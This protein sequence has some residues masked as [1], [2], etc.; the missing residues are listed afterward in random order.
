[1]RPSFSSSSI[2]SP[3]QKPGKPFVFF[4][5]I[6]FHK[7]DLCVACWNLD[8]FNGKF[9]EEILT[10]M[11]DVINEMSLD[12]LYL[13]EVSGP[14]KT[15]PF[16][17]LLG[18]LD[19]NYR[20]VNMR[21]STDYWAAAIYREDTVEFEGIFSSNQSDPNYT[22]VRQGNS[23]LFKRIPFTCGWTRIKQDEKGK[24]EK[25]ESYLITGLHLAA[26][27]F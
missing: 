13:I 3:E 9:T 24:Q 20:V 15:P 23:T 26:G 6:S 14:T 19:H 21:V 10:I 12:I 16:K 11:A 1:M 18:K 2:F 7:D 17:N 5:L 8:H 25:K 27:G 22:Y 4:V